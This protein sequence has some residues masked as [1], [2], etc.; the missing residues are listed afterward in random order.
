MNGI[1][2]Q[3]KHLKIKNIRTTYNKASKQNWKLLKKLT[4]LIYIVKTGQ[5]AS[6]PLKS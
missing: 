4:R 3:K 6:N 2:Y 5:M 1:W